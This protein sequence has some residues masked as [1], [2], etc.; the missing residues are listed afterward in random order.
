MLVSHNI[1]KDKQLKEYKK[2][3]DDFTGLKKLAKDMEKEIKKNVD[4]ETSNN[5]K[6]IQALE[7]SM[8]SFSNNLKK[9]DFY[10]YKTGRDLAVQKLKEIRVEVAELDKKIEDYGFNSLKFNQ[11]GLIENCKV[12]VVSIKTEI[13]SMN[14]LWDKINELETQFNSWLNMSWSVSKPYDMEDDAKKS[15]KSL[16]EMK[17]DKKSNTYLGIMDVLKA[18]LT[19]LP[20]IADLRDD[21]M[22]E[23]HWDMVRK[24]VGVQ[25]E[26]P[27]KLI[28]KDIWNLNL[29]KYQEDVEEICDQAKQEAKM[30]RTL[31]KLT[32][33]YAVVKYQF[34]PMKDSDINQFRL[35]EEEFEQ[36]ENDQM[37]V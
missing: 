19:F 35:S 17:C 3:T 5:Q 16:K 12:Q 26:D 13:D 11:P 36:L 4:H 2:L 32:E 1:P 28:V 27:N 7:D 37:A 20:L 14:A 21:A 23:R 18:W 25:F 29:N 6:Q 33:V 22:R 8:K 15:M 10:Q 30:E 24:K 34:T 9:R 31:K